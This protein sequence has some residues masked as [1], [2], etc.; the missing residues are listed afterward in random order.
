MRVQSDPGDD[1]QREHGVRIQPSRD[2]DRFK[3]QSPCIVRLP[4]GKWRL[5]YT[6]VGPAKPFPDCQG[7]I[8]SA[9]AEDGLNFTA[10]PGIRLAPQP[11]LPPMSLRVLSPSIARCGDEVWRMYFE[12]RGPSH[13]PTVICSAVSS[14]LLRWDLEPGIRLQATGG[15]SGPRYVALPD[16]RG[17]L[18]CVESEYGPGGIG[19]GTPVSQS[20]I[21]AISS[22]GQSFQREPGYRLRD[23]QSRYDSAGITAAEVIAP[24]SEREGWTMLYSAWQA[25]DEGI[26]PP[27]HPSQD[28][29]A[30]ENGR[31]ADFAAQSIACD[32]AGYRS[33]IFIS[34]SRD[35]LQWSPGQVMIEGAGYDSDELD[36]VHAEDMSVT[37]LS[38]NRY[39]MY[40][41][42]CDRRGTWR[43][44]SA[45]FNRCERQVLSP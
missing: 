8:L 12:A 16:G 28:P 14:D 40:Y 32:L 10:E 38:P 43:I 30:I 7:Y 31:S 29:R 44:L 4:S 34:Y 11:S 18:Y 21:S 45:Q 20:V 19:S 37:A 25:P 35:G 3:L 17:R 36:A 41:A 15:V 23:R 39:R 9:A 6:A 33:R 2:L 42:A 5:F 13:L 26:V 27:V 1:W 24:S 22:D